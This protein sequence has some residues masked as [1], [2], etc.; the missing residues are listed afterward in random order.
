MGNNDPTAVPGVKG[1]EGSN[2]WLKTY[3][4]WVAMSAADAL[5]ASAS[6]YGMTAAWA[7]GIPQVYQLRLGS[8]ETCQWQTQNDERRV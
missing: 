7:G 6:G 8:E 2:P 4:D 5:L 3:A 1:D